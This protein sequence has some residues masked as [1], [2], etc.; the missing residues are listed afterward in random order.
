MSIYKTRNV[1]N[2]TKYTLLDE[3][4]IQRQICNEALYKKVLELTAPIRDAGFVV[5]SDSQNLNNGCKADI[6]IC[7]SLDPKIN[8]FD[9]DFDFVLYDYDYG[10]PR[11]NINVNQAKVIIR[12]DKEYNIAKTRLIRTDILYK[13]FGIYH[14]FIKDANTDNFR[15]IAN[16]LKTRYSHIIQNNYIIMKKQIQQD[17]LFKLTE[18]DVRLLCDTIN[19]HQEY[20]VKAHF[21]SD[22]DRP[23]FAICINKDLEN[24]DIKYSERWNSGDDNQPVPTLIDWFLPGDGSYMSIN[25][26]KKDDKWAIKVDNR[27]VYCIRMIDDYINWCECSEF[28]TIQDACEYLEKKFSISH[29][30]Y[31]RYSVV[32]LTDLKK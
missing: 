25:V 11:I 1:S 10:T 9:L 30:I 12:D 2:C 8:S 5:C 15:R 3:N 20:Y 16:A 18:D 17:N 4:L 28:E 31:K 24:E 21:V 14:E 23:K 7:S 32:D 27:P 26:E 13:H 29:E 6:H 19:N 22:V